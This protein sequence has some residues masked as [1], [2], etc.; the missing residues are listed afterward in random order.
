MLAL[1]Y[2]GLTAQRGSLYCGTCAPLPIRRNIR[3]QGGALPGKTAWLAVIV[4]HDYSNKSA[5]HLAECLREQ[6]HPK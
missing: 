5:K 4:V 1:K 2:R 3:R 6:T